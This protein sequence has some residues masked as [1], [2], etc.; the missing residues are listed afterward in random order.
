MLLLSARTRISMTSLF[1]RIRPA[2]RSHWELG[3]IE[4]TLQGLLY[5]NLA[6]QTTFLQEQTR[7]CLDC[8]CRVV[9][10][11]T[12]MNAE[13][14]ALCDFLQHDPATIKLMLMPRYTFKS[15]IITIGHTLWLLANDPNARLL[16]YSDATEKAEG[17]LTGI[18]AHI[19]GAIPGSLFRAV[20]GP[21][22]VDPKRGVWNQGA[23][24]VAPRTHAHVEPSVDTAGTE[25]SKVGK[26]YS[27][28]KFDDV[29]SDKTVT[30]RELMDKTASVY[31]NAGSLLQPSGQV[32]VAGTR[33]HFGDLYGRLLVELKG[34]ARFAVFHR[35]S[36]EGTRYFFADIGKDSLTPAFLAQKKAA[37]GSYLFS[38][39]YQ[40]EPVDD[41]TAT[42]KVSD[43]AFY[44]SHALPT[45]L[46][47][48]ACLD[49]IPPHE[50]TA[51]DDAAITV[52]GTDHALNLY[53]LDL[54]AGRLQPSEQIDELFRL[55]A[56]W[57]FNAFGVETNAFQ[58]V[59]RRDIEFR[60]QQER[61][62][63]PRFRFFHIE[64]FVGSSLPNKEHRIR[65]LQPYHERGALKFPGTSLE[66]LT[67]QYQ[68]LAY[69]M[70]QFP[71]SAHDDLLDS[72]AGHIPLHRAGTT[73]ETPQDIPWSS[74][75]WFEREQQQEAV[76]VMARRPRWTRT[77]VPELSFS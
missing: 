64:E 61:L 66:T 5:E 12:D 26:H 42:F 34:D 40:N 39:L 23:I 77:P 49:P 47:V 58:K 32:D 63:N 3:E 56:K 70:L 52:V 31:K 16:L 19:T 41:E 25:T 68:T 14:D 67:G 62:K 28:L 18:K 2:C 72:L 33:W 76:H 75:A 20:Y 43:F 53:L 36:F 1:D 55:H 22:E 21:W 35:K 65:G 9:L 57:N 73:Y 15:S 69:Q 38:A 54:V 46:Y 29:V 17:F 24:T 60:Y 6:A 50:G 30:T 44:D 27:R 8:F 37:Q 51:G 71:K 48:T 10:G 74:A 7:A 45:G 11:F 13:H 59:M 4:P